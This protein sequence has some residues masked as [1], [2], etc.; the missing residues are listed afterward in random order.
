MF[1]LSIQQIWTPI[2]Y[3][4]HQK[5]RRPGR[6]SQLRT[7]PLGKDPAGPFAAE[8]SFIKGSYSIDPCSFVDD[9]GGCCL[10]FGSIWGGELQ[11]YKKPNPKGPSDFDASMLGPKE[12]SG[13]GAAAAGPRVAR[14]RDSD[15]LEFDSSNVHEIEI[16]D[17]ETKQK[18]PA[19]DHD[20][21]FF[22]TTWVHKYNGKYYSSYS[23]GDTHNT[24]Y[25]I[26]DNP[27]GPFVYGGVVLGP[28]VGWK[29]HHSVVEYCKNK[30]GKGRWWVFSHDCELSG[31]VHH[32]RSV[33]LREVWYNEKGD[34][35]LV[36]PER[37]E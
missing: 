13:A 11:C 2:R 16:L 7:N 28:V 20:L 18:I 30:D 3:R 6:H 24:C 37:G 31:G 22:K 10:Y 8:P 21:R 34:M 23:T 29:N 19:D 25:A 15:W 12:V 5:L 36:K 9:D 32:L 14:M 17:P 33:R 1:C 26:G 27:R 4:L 35:I